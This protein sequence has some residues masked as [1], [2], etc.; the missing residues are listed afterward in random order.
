[1]P[2]MLNPGQDNTE[3]L[4]FEL[5]RVFEL[6]TNGQCTIRASVESDAAAILSF[7]PRTHLESDF[8]NYLPGEFDFSL[9]QEREFL[10]RHRETPGHIALIAEM[11][12]QI[13]GTA[14]ASVNGLRR[15]NHQCELGIVVGKSHWGRGIG[16]KLMQTLID[17]GHAEGFRK[18]GLRVFVSNDR[19]IA[20]YRSLGFVDEGR[21][22]GDVLAGDGTY[23]DTIIMSKF[24]V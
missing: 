22:V 21:L 14:G 20:L 5:P 6:D 1:M 8:L 12:G 4:T 9:E 7:L 11:E 23:G 24:L 15:Y 16:R 13:V 2:A 18:M 3:R 10:R 19:A 17:W